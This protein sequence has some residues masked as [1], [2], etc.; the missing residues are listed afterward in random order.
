LVLFPEDRLG[1]IAE[2]HHARPGPDGLLLAWRY[3]PSLR[4]G[5][6]HERRAAFERSHGSCEVEIELPN[7]LTDMP[8]F[9]AD[10]GWLADSRSTADQL[11]APD[12]MPAIVFPEGRQ[13]E[14]R[15]LARE[16]DTALVRRLKQDAIA[17]GE[18]LCCACCG[19]DFGTAYGDVGFGFIEVHHTV[20]VSELPEEGGVTRVEDLVFVCANCHRMLHR[21]RP[22]LTLPELKQLLR[23]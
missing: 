11:R 15:H 13:F 22:W 9:L 6:N 18:P 17:S 8:A 10:V 5:R 2:L 20:P 7:T 1:P 4:D 19:F 23:R 3:R 14:R 21:R 16:R 12:P